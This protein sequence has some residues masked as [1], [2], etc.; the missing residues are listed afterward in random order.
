M[1]HVV[2]PY[3]RKIEPFAW[4]EDAFTEAE[5][6]YLRQITSAGDQVAK[7]GG[8]D[9]GGANPDVRR[10]KIGWMACTPE[11]QWVFDRLSHVIS[12]LNAQFYG[13][14][15]TVFGEAIQLTNYL[16]EEEGMYGWHQ[17]FGGLLSRKLSLVMQLSDPEEYEGGELQIMVGGDKPI[18]INKQ[19]GLVVVFPSWAVHQVTPVTKGLRQSLVAWVSGP[20]FR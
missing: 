5:L 17:D 19:K 12:S 7:V 3:S 16:A 2:T 15:L 9:K 8:K 1:Q 14:D 20:N 4:W 11:S 18:S 6:N 13:F 10:S